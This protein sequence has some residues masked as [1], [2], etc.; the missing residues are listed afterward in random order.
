MINGA[1]YST[2]R[3]LNQQQTRI[4]FTPDFPHR[5][6][7]WRISL[8]VFACLR[9]YTRAH[10]Y[11]TYR[12]NAFCN[13]TRAR[14]TAYTHPAGPPVGR[15]VGV[16]AKSGGMKMDIHME[17]HARRH[18]AFLSPHEWTVPRDTRVPFARGHRRFARV[19]INGSWLAPR[20]VGMDGTDKR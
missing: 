18:C 15:S 17:T 6:G 1:Y 10:T 16:S 19:V 3:R 2:A 12:R 13:D 5:A 8:P 4:N 14:A 7:P 11:V 20:D 9:V